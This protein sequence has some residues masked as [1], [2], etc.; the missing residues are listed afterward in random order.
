MSERASESP[1][2]APAGSPAPSRRGDRSSEVRWALADS[3]TIAVR[4]FTY[5][6]REPARLLWSLGYPIVS[7]LLFGF[8]FGSAMSV[9][10]GGDYREFLLPGMFAMTMA[11]GAGAT[12]VAVTMDA[13]KGVTDRFRS[14]PMARSGVVVG[15][16]IADLANSVLDLV[17][18]IGCGL[19]VGWH[20]RNGLLDALAAVGLLLLLRFAFIWL[21]I[22]LGLI[23]PSPET[24]NNLWALLFPITMLSNA[25]VAP[26]QLP[27]WL[28]AIADW[29][30]ISATVTATRS[31]F[32]N[33]EAVSGSWISQ[34]AELMA[35]VW[36]LLF[37]AIFLPL[38]VRRYRRLSR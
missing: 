23:I 35:V 30:P 9:Y 15:R 13:A 33:P 31:L 26:A 29:N 18:L 34:N 17:I 5:W 20:V 24:A 10:G 7:V 25:F 22:Y 6:V 14:M 36:P 3:W 1:N 4:D 11:F 27:G 8:V 21:G 38:S 28:S 19:V 16:S 2:T 12:M 32:G 37:V